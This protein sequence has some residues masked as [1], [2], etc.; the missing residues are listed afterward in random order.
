[1]STVE[2]PRMR[3]CNPYLV[4]SEYRNGN[5]EQRS[6][7]TNGRSEPMRAQTVFPK[8]PHVCEPWAEGRGVREDFHRQEE[9][10]NN[11][12]DFHVCD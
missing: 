10:K 6:E 1:M 5:F 8:A 9:N 2:A 3:T 7:F 12:H 4:H 11:V